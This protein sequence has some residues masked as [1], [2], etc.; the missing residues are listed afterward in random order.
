MKVIKLTTEQ[1]EDLRGNYNGNEFN[2]IQDADGNWIVGLSVLNNG[3]FLALRETLLACPQINH[4]PI[5]P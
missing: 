3:N 2:P 4:N 5:K 1:A